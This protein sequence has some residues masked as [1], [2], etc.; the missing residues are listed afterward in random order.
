MAVDQFGGELVGGLRVH[1]HQLRGAFHQSQEV[2]VAGVPRI[3]QQ[4]VPARVHQQAAGQQQCA[5]AAGRDQD[6]LRIDPH[7]VT[8]L[9]EPGDGLAQRGQPARGGVAGV[10]GGQ[11]GL[12]GL[13]DRRGR[14][15]VRFPD[16]QVDDIVACLL[17]RLR[18]GQQRHHVERFDFLAAATVA[19]RGRGGAHAADDRR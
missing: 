4:P 3:G 14:G 19:R 18:A 5:R 15:E 8:L 9:V 2:T 13:H 17:Q 12:A 7:L 6:T 10:A 16:L 1:R 11:G